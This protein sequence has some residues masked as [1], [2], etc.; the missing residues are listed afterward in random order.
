[1]RRGSPLIWFLLIRH[2]LKGKAANFC[3]IVFNQNIKHPLPDSKRR[4]RKSKRSQWGLSTA[5]VKRRSNR[6]IK[7]GGSLVGR[8]RLGD[9]MQPPSK[10]ALQEKRA[11]PLS[12]G[13]PDDQEG[14]VNL[15]SRKERRVP[16]GQIR[17]I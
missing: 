14:A 3:P 10:K 2:N 8:L 1:M 4:G 9:G 12:S 17:Q 13:S 16:P 5:W 11:S 7:K 6:Q 15:R